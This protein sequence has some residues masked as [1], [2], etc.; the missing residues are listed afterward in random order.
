MPAAA[1]SAAHRS[2]SNGGSAMTATATAVSAPTA[3]AGKSSG[4]VSRTAV[5]APAPAWFQKPR[6]TSGA[7]GFLGL[8]SGSGNGSDSEGSSNGS[9]ISATTAAAVR[10]FQTTMTSARLR[11]RGGGECDSVTPCF[12][13]H[14]GHHRKHNGAPFFPPFGA[15][16]ST[17]IVSNILPRLR[18]T[19]VQGAKHTHF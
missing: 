7:P 13:K 3:A 8:A 5:A 10:F 14:A 19:G 9:S 18:H 2:S 17:G 1:A 6:C 4:G 16:C 12:R 15:V 11:G